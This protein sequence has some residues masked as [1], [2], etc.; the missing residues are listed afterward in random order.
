MLC[1]HRTSFFIPFI[2]DQ[3]LIFLVTNHP[4]SFMDLHLI[5]KTEREHEFDE[6][7][8]FKN[9]QKYFT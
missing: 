9:V 3:Y 2:S 1:D 7:K 5:L 6:H 8:K 4:L